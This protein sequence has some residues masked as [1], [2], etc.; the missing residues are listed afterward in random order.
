LLSTS[1]LNVISDS[2]TTTGGG[3]GVTGVEPPPPL[4]QEAII[5]EN[6]TKTKQT[7]FIYV[8]LYIKTNLHK[9]F[10]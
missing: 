3:V 8:Q 5:K 2:A 10:N 9:I 1:T 7:F 6:A 4:L